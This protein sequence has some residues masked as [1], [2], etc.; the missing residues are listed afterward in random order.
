MDGA[1]TGLSIFLWI[2]FAVPVLLLAGFGIALHRGRGLSLLAGY[3]EMSPEERKRLNQRAIGRFLGKTMFAL[4][5]CTLLW[6][7]GIS[8][9]RMWIF[10]TGFGLF[11]AV[12]LGAVLY[13]N[14]GKRFRNP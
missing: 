13:V 7:I 5:A 8:T 11:L 3:S 10:W 9:H 14:K 4:A 12:I 2:V 1:E 6:P